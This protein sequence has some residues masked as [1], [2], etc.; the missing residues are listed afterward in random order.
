MKNRPGW[1]PALADSSP[2]ASPARGASQKSPA[3]ATLNTSSSHRNHI[4]PLG[5][6][7]SAIQCERHAEAQETVVQ[8]LP[9]ALARQARPDEQAG[10]KEQQLHQVDVLERTEQ[11]EAEPARAIDDRVRPPPIRG[12]IERERSIGLRVE[13]GDA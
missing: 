2:K 10:Q 5:Q 12:N 4:G 3:A 7:G 6:N 1:L 13:V 9:A 8:E 11:V